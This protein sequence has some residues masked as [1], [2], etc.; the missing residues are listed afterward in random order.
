MAFEYLLVTDCRLHTSQPPEEIMQL[1]K[2]RDMLAYMKQNEEKISKLQGKKFE[3]FPVTRVVNG[4]PTETTAG[5]LLRIW[6]SGSTLVENQC[7]TCPINFR[8][9][10]V[11]CYGAVNY[12]LSEQ[13]E[14]WLAENFR[15]TK[16]YG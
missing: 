15:P 8:Q 10:T 5:A 14:S 7:P 2:F 11:G 12:P 1:S 4:V 13:F 3:D 6:Q 9:R 16:D